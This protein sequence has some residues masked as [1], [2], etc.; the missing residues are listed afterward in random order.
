VAGT[1]ADPDYRASDMPLKIDIAS[2]FG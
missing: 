2:K 1:V